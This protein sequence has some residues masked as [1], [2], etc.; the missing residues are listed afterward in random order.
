MY[1]SA[2]PVQCA[3]SWYIAKNRRS[4]K[5]LRPSNFYFKIFKAVLPV[6]DHFLFPPLFLYFFPPTSSSLQ[7][8]FALSANS[9]D[10]FSHSP[11]VVLQPLQGMEEDFSWDKQAASFTTGCCLFSLPSPDSAGRTIDSQSC[12]SFGIRRRLRLLPACPMSILW[13]PQQDTCSPT[14]KSYINGPFGS[15]ELH[16]ASFIFHPMP[17]ELY[18]L[19]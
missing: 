18:C 2:K 17:L 11:H 1:A 6:L 16:F 13:L 12:F 5:C 14:S 8:S 15:W 7:S 19:L 9:E 3:L 10:T 4:T